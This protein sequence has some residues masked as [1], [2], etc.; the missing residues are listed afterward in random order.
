MKALWLGTPGLSSNAA[1]LQEVGLDLAKYFDPNDPGALASLIDNLHSN[2]EAHA[3]LQDKVVRSHA[4]LRT[5]RD[6]AEDILAAV[7]QRPAAVQASS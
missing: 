3:A 1:A 5:W 6:V 4:S 7:S 2:P